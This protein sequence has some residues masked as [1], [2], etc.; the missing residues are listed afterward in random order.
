MNY[1]SYIILYDNNLYFKSKDKYFEIHYKKSTLDKGIILDEDDFV[2]K[3]LRKLKDNKLSSF[4]FNKKLLVIYDNRISKND[5]NKLKSAFNNLN[6]RN[7]I[8]KSDVSLIPLNKKDN[9]LICSNNYKFLYID[10]F[11]TKKCI[12]LESTLTDNEINIIVMNR[13]IKKNLFIIGN[14]DRIIYKN[15]NYYL[16]D[17]II[18]FFLN[19]IDSHR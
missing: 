13:S 4:F 12:T 10:K 11:N 1:N 5:F 14:T 17:T 2:K 16:Y 19:I 15:T 6:Y 18:D 3:Y 8:F 9:Y 7:I